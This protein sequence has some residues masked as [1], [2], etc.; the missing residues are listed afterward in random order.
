MNIKFKYSKHS[1]PFSGFGKSKK[2]ILVDMSLTT[3]HHGHVRLLKKASELGEVIVA[4]VSDEEIFRYK[5]FYPILCFENRK[6]IALAF[7]YVEEV[8]ESGWLIDEQYLNDN[9]IDLLVHGDDNQ[10][11]IPADRLV[12]FERTEEIS[13]TM[14]RTSNRG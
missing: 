1:K 2:R 10:N 12:I 9:N 14:L 5:G 13:S 3:V 6:E 8:I 11:P 7:K 4:L